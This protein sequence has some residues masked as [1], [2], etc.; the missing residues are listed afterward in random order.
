MNLRH[1]PQLK[2]ILDDNIEEAMRI[3][4]LISEVIKKDIEAQNEREE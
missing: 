2:I 4:K 1:I 3:E